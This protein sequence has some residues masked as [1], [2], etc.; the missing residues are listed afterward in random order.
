MKNILFLSLI[1]FESLSER[2]IYTDLLREFLRHHHKVYVVSPMEKRKGKETCLIFDESPDKGTDMD[3]P[4]VADENDCQILKVR[5]GNT[6]KTNMIEKGISTLRITSQIKKAIEKYFRDIHF[7]LV[8]YATPPI[9]LAPVVRWIKQRDH[10]VTYLMLKDIFPQNAVDL[11]M[12]SSKGPF[13]WYFR[14]REKRLY[15]CSD[16]IGCMSRA[17][18]N[19]LLEHN[20]SI[21]RSQVELCPNSIEIVLEEVG[22]NSVTHEERMALREYYGLPT[23]AVI[24]LYGGNL[25]KP[26][27]VPYIVDCIRLCESVEDAYFVVCGTGTEYELLEE[28]MQEGAKNLCLIH[29]LPKGEYDHLVSVC[30]VGLV[31][32]DSRFT[33]PN[34]PSRLLSYMEKELPVLAATDSNTD[35][36]EVITKGEFG[37]HCIS[38][39]T[40][41]FRDL[42]Q[43]M[44]EERAGLHNMGKRGRAY[45]ETHYDVK[46]NYQTIMKHFDEV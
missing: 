3:N 9:T 35:V 21:M 32:L 10:A 36:G 1:D 43:K 29:G 20:P 6:Q 7:D 45:L 34:F 24:F 4:E 28:F 44:V 25:G 2:N 40:E 39:Q 31:F 15:Q 26:Q 18:E 5:I 42:V 17:N 13:Y 22:K 14:Q 37:Y 27:D 41:P 12:F 38:T 30:D 16:Y 11:H 23:E 33:I 8:L 19:Y 46:L